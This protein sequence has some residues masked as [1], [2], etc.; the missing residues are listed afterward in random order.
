MKLRVSQEKTSVYLIFERH[1]LLNTGS[2]ANARDE[3][4]APPLTNSVT[5]LN[6]LWPGEFYLRYTVKRC[7]VLHMCQFGYYQPEK[8][9]TRKLLHK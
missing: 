7:P 4:L 8:E 5:L 6:L 9:G 3:I 1:W 2:K